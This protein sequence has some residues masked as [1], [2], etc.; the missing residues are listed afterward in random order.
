MSPVAG[1]VASSAKTKNTPNGA[2]SGALTPTKDP[3][4]RG[5]L[6]PPPACRYL[7]S[8]HRP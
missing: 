2:V 4:P 7:P 5:R 1:P 6:S 8:T 3:R